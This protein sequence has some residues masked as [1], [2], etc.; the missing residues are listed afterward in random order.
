MKNIKANKSFFIFFILL[1]LMFI[2]SMIYAFV[3]LK[4]PPLVDST[5]KA[6]RLTYGLRFCAKLLPAAAGTGCLIGWAMEFG[7]NP[8]GS[9]QRFSYA[10]FA[11]F[12]AIV[13]ISLAFVFLL[14]A[15]A[16]FIE[17]R[18]NLNLKR[19]A[20]MP[21]LLKQYNAV[22]ERL[23]NAGQFRLAFDYAK[24]AA[25]IDAENKD[26]K[27]ILYLSELSLHEEESEPQEQEEA[28]LPDAAERTNAEDSADKKE[29]AEL[30]ETR[31]LLGSAQECLAK[32]DFFGAHYYS[33]LALQRISPKDINA[34]ALKQIAAAA[35]NEL[36][37]SRL[38][39]SSEAQKIFKKKYEGY[40]NLIN[41]E[42][43]KAYY[44]FK[45]LSLESRQLAIDPD[46]VRYLA[47]AESHIEKQSFFIDETFNLQTFESASNVYFKLKNPDGTTDVIF[48]NG[49][50]QAE[51]K[52]D[53]IQ[54]LRGLSIFTLDL[55]GNFMN[56]SYT[57]YAKMESLAAKHFDDYALALVGVRNKYK[58]VPYIILNSI[59][60]NRGSSVGK[61]EQMTGGY[62]DISSR[63][64]KI[65]PMEYSDFELIKGAAAGADTMTLA[66]LFK[67][68]SR[69]EQYGYSAE[70]FMQALLN[71]LLYPLFL[72]N[73]FLLLAWLAWH[74][75]TPQNAA[76]KFSW[77]LLFPFMAA[78][79]HLL[80]RISKGAF[81]VL[82]YGLLSLTGKTYALPVGTV[83]YA[84][85]L[86]IL[87]LMF[88]ACRNTDK[89]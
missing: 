7:R 45:T 43:F 48:I 9:I 38:L 61:P 17:P 58:S 89:D 55:Y 15:A 5:I 85:L 20:G 49:I 73:I 19:Y 46:V 28:A 53:L 88:L 67:F 80:Y 63:N 44:I 39:E 64:Y 82:N 8:D 16:E 54:Y 42:Y 31:K 23:Y 75:R 35:W 4:L 81:K 6:Y 66:A 1:I 57:V 3:F 14:T 56:G 33:H 41:E 34:A 25:E 47:I 86:F 18:L 51:G 84:L 76:F 50:A 62:M 69:A 36:N 11:R 30:Y 71:R 26:T 2:G 87:S 12:K 27:R 52:N 32:Q 77:S 79:L 22:A 37:Q 60:R 65:L 29:Y 74:G 59:D 10:M 40:V 21:S 24:L 13:V 68:A 83:F 70:V 78:T 72:L